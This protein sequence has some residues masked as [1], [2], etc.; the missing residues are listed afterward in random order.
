MEVWFA[1]PG[2]VISRNDMLALRCTLS[3]G[4]HSGS[5]SAYHVMEAWQA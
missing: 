1:E 4:F 5:S 2:D 3:V